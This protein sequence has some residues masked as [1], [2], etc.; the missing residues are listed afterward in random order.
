MSRA[1]VRTVSYNSDI[2]YSFKAF[3]FY[4]WHMSG[5]NLLVV[6]VGPTA[7]G[8]TSAA[9]T[10]AKHFG[11]EIISADSRQFYQE[12][13]IG[14]AK[15]SVKELNEV[16]HHFINS[17]T[18]DED[19]DAGTF[20]TAAESL[21]D[22]LFSKNPIQFMV[23]G[24]GLYIKAF[25]DGLD[26]MPEIDPQIRESLNKVFETEGLEL[27]LEELKYKDPIYYDMVDKHN[28]QRVIRGLEVIRGTKK[29]YSDFR[30]GSSSKNHAFKIL[31]IGLEMDRPLLYER[32]DRRMDEMISQGLFEEAGGLYQ[33]RKKNALQTVGYKEIFDFIAGNYDK[34]EAVRL[35]KRNSRRYA[36]RQMTWFKKDTAVQWYTAEQI[37]LILDRIDQERP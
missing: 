29:R 25:C 15:P 14:T 5:R 22:Q 12:M 32:I 11:G 17:H 23:G 2:F 26:D 30:L 13:E 37:D 33:Q 27:L 31:K 19:Y 34:E 35:L 16:P 8:K 10:M 3:M 20:A 7:V 24:S 6:V 28:P 4:L 21:L 1:E 36:K 9:V 18:I